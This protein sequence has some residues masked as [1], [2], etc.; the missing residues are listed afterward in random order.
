[1]RI[2]ASVVLQEVCGVVASPAAKGEHVAVV[3]DR[4]GAKASWRS[5]AYLNGGVF[6]RLGESGET[7][8]PV[9]GFPHGRLS[10]PQHKPRVVS[11]LLVAQA[12]EK[13]GKKAI[14][15]GSFGLR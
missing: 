4:L 12:L 1:M 3:L 11:G 8:K 15:F 6:A 2:G 7:P 5:G 9:W 14:E 10:R 13:F